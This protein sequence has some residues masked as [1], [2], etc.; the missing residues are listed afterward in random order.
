MIKIDKFL[1]KITQ[2]KCYYIQKFNKIYI[3]NFIDRKKYY[4]IHYKTNNINQINF[5]ER[6]N[7]K[8]ITN[9][10]YLKKTI[11]Y[12]ETYDIGSFFSA[13]KK[14]MPQI[15]TFLKNNKTQSRFYIDKKFP[16]KFRTQYRI[17]MASNFFKKQH[18]TDLFL[19]KNKRKILGLILLKNDKIKNAFLINLIIV[20]KRN[21]RSGIGKSLIQ[22]AQNKFYKK[23]KYIITGTQKQNI[24]AL[25][26]YQKMGFKIFKEDFAL[27]HFS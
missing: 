13:K 23:I 9:N 19:Y 8:K 14:D 18:S 11:A 12:Q 7:F 24:S 15:K 27:H 5:L 10:V 21:L 16:S 17:E 26:F 22:H 20:N 2:Y 6:K 4:F 3:N 1:T 25:T